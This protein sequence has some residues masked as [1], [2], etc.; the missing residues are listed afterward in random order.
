MF[1]FKK[2][3]ELFR[4]EKEISTCT[5]QALDFLFSF[6]TLSLDVRIREP[7]HWMRSKF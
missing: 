3:T 5:Q 4:K 7:D 2:Y 1:A 6:I